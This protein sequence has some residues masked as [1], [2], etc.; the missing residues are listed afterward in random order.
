MLVHS[1]S[2]VA[3]ALLIMCYNAQNNK[4]GISRR[5]NTEIVFTKPKEIRDEK[6]LGCFPA[7]MC[8]LK[9]FVQFACK[10]AFTKARD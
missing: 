7:M 3:F 4:A 2:K 1:S 10:N 5:E 6:L 9:Y 8:P